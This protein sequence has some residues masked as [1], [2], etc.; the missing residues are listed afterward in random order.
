MYSEP[1][2]GNFILRKRAGLDYVFSLDGTNNTRALYTTSTNRLFAVR[3]SN[4]YEIL[5]VPTLRGTLSS[6]FGAVSFADNGIKMTIADGVVFKSY[7]LDTNTLTDITDV[8][9]PTNTPQTANIDGYYFGFNPNNPELGTYSWSDVDDPLIWSEARYNVAQKVPDRLVGMIANAGELW[10]FGSKSY[11]VHGNT[12]IFENEWQLIGGSDGEIGCASMQSICKNSNSVYWL[13]ADKEGHAQVYRSVGYQAQKISTFKQDSLISQISDISD[14]IGIIYQV[15]GHVFYKLTFQTGDLTLVYDITTGI[16]HEE[17]WWN[18]ITMLQERSR[19]C[20]HAF[21]NGKNYI[22]DGRN[23]NVYTLSVD[24]YEDYNN[25]IVCEVV[26]PHHD[27]MKQPLFYHSL[28]IDAE[29]GVGDYVNTPYIQICSSVDG[30]NTFGNWRNFSLGLAGDYMKRVKVNR[31]GR[32]LQRV[33]KLRHS[34]NTKFN[35]INKAIAE[36]ESGV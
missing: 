5:N 16:W 35:L 30:G 9:A 12:G 22:G 36:V 15:N 34:A 14:A 28:E 31:L 26:F 27:D 20:C 25:P 24:K 7:D 6:S 33:F 3:G 10:L 17:T 21:F 23:G 19:D 4:L 11:E 32:S 18:D 13:G 29:M 8:D 1:L 2:E